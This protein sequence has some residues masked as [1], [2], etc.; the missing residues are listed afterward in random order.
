M[1]NK[2]VFFFPR[3]LSS[4]Y[5]F[6]HTFCDHAYRVIHFVVPKV[7]YCILTFVKLNCQTKNVLFLIKSQA[8]MKMAPEIHHNVLKLFKPTRGFSNKCYYF[9]I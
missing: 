2:I 9:D 4:S 6:E 5:C 3:A 7:Q 8:S 1:T